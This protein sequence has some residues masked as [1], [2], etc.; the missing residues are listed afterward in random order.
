MVKAAIADE[1]ALLLC[2]PTGTG[3]STY[4]KNILSNFLDAQ[5]YIT[6]E[7]GFSA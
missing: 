5:K 7:I 1:Y 4:I 3:K 6:I 2:G